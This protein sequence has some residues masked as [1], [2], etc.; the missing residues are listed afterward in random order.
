MKNP[1]STENSLSATDKRQARRDPSNFPWRVATFVLLLT[2]SG[3]IFFLNTTK[4]NF[5]TQMEIQQDKIA[6]LRDQLRDIEIENR[7]LTDQLSVVS[8]PDFT[9]IRLNSYPKANEFFALVYWNQE[10]H[11]VYLDPTSLPAIDEEMQ[12]QLWRAD[13]QHSVDLG[14]VLTGDIGFQQMKNT[15]TAN[16]FVITLEPIGGSALPIEERII[17]I[18]KY[19]N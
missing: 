9:R 12:Y 14:T 16:A 11:Q 3:L 15:P 5:S 6:A 7:K 1:E 19:Q 13:R 2:A 18:G 8:D 10:N 17:A 4:K